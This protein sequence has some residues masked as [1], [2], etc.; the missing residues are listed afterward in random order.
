MIRNLHAG[1]TSG[2]APRLLRPHLTATA[3]FTSVIVIALLAALIVLLEWNF[4]ARIVPLTVTLIALV[5]AALSLGNELFLRIAPAVRGS[6]PA[7]TDAPV[8]DAARGLDL[9][10]VLIRAAE[11]FGWVLAYLVAAHL[12]GMLPAM[13]LFVG[14]SVRFWGRESL[15]QALLLAVGI[16]AFSALL[17]D[18]VLAIPWP[19]NVLG[20][21]FP[22]LQ[23]WL[24]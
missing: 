17:F 15:R 7:P 1:L 13:F 18:Q 9:R 22:A 12:I 23:P 5:C 11:F 19:Q 14:A 4:E 16:T 8:L 2:N 10:I 6:E 21:A 24:K 20:N 3:A